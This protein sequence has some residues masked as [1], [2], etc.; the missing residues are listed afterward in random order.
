MRIDH[1][2]IGIDGTVND[3]RSSGNLSRPHLIPGLGPDSPADDNPTHR[4]AERA[5]R[6][7]LSMTAEVGKRYVPYIRRHLRRAHALLKSPLRELSV[8]L[9]ADKTMSD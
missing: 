9:V 3:Q 1:A 6:M 8:A 2:R 4:P 5:I 7:K